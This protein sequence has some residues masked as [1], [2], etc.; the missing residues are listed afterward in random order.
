MEGLSRMSHI[1]DSSARQVRKLLQQCWPIGIGNFI[2]RRIRNDKARCCPILDREVI[3]QLANLCQI[4]ARLG[5]FK[6]SF[7]LTWGYRH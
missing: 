6:A 4:C 5:N 3:T 1:Q 7:V 2:F